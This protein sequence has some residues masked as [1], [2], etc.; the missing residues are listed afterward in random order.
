MPPEA[1]RDPCA[2]GVGGRQH[3]P[4]PPRGEQLRAAEAQH[5]GVPPRPRGPTVRRGAGALA[6]VLDQ[7]DARLL[8][9]RPRRRHVDHAAVQVGDEHGPRLR[10]E[11]GADR[12]GVDLPVVRPHVDR[13]GR[14]SQRQHVRGVRPEVVPGHDHLVRGRHPAA[15]QRQLHR[16]GSP[17]AQVHAGAGVGLGQRRPQR[18]AVRAVVAAPVAGGDQPPQDGGD[19]GVARRPRRRAARPQRDPPEDR[20]ATGGK[21][22][23][24]V[25][26]TC[27]A[28]LETRCGEPRLKA[29]VSHSRR[30]EFVR[31]AP[32]SLRHG[33]RF[34]GR[35]QD[36]D[37]R[38]ARRDVP[39]PRAVGGHRD[40]RPGGGA[41]GH[42]Q[43]AGGWGTRWARSRAP[44][45]AVSSTTSSPRSA[46][47]P[48][49]RAPPRR[50]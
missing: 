20:G 6:G 41:R 23:P 27:R 24:A 40:E 1:G 50:T 22:A 29:S 47:S 42:R 43:P 15:D 13:H 3:G 18:L 33:R 28:D 25:P 45:S 2:D 17:G 35:R 8:A 32:H 10:G 21:A 46:R 36:D 16:R 49:A 44:V 26:Q 14:G 48:R 4:A 19:G 34:P 9:Q 39:R 31:A 38:P 12:G 11:G 7:G 5:A 37:P 30:P